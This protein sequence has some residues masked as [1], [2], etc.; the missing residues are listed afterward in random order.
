MSR[1]FDNLLANYRLTLC[2]LT[3]S[4]VYSNIKI[5]YSANI[6]LNSKHGGK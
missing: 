1:R 5:R 3:Q 4:V 6:R 2:V